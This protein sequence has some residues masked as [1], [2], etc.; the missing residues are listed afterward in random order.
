MATTAD[1]I[2]A[3]KERHHAT[4]AAGDYAAVAAYIED[5]AALCAERAG[6]GPGAELLDIATGTGNV[7]LEA[8]QRGATVTGLDL[9]PGLL[10]TARE[11]AAAAG[12]DIAWVTGDAEALPFQDGSFDA[13][14]S[15]FGLMFAPRHAVAARELTRVL[16]PGGR[17]VLS[18]WAA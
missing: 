10:E 9:T 3:L 4:W 2:A 12:L 11:R 6:V 17:F 16:R 13:A 15:T 8:A 1:E 5:V 18:T 14:T 7:A